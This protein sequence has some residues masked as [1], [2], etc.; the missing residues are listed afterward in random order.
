M[1]QIKL[2]IARGALLVGFNLG[3]KITFNNFK[4]LQ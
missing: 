2:P 4:A 1:Q 3:P